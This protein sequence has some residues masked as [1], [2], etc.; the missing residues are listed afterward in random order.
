MIDIIDKKNCC[1]CTACASIC[2]H[3]AISMQPDALGFL[4]P[5]V[6]KD[7][8]VNCGVCDKV[9]A[10]NGEYDKSYNFDYPLAY[11]ARHKDLKQIQKS[12]SGAA[13]AFLSD[14]ILENGGVVYGAGYTDFF[15]VVHQ[16]ATTKEERDKLRRSKYVQSDLTNVFVQVK[17]DLC[18]GLTVLFSGTP[19]QAAGLNSYIGKKFREN[20]ILVDII[21]HGVPG[22]Y[23][24]RDYLT[25]LQKKERKKLI[26]INFRDKELGGWRGSVESFTFEKKDKRTYDFRFYDQITIRQSCNVCPY[27]NFKRP[28]DITIGDFWGVEKTRAAYMGED[29][30]GCS[31][32]LLN[33]NKGVYLFDQVKK[34]IEYESM[35][36][37]ECVQPQLQNPWVAHPQRLQFEKEYPALGFERTMKKYKIMGWRRHLDRQIR[38]WKNMFPQTWKDGI[39]NILHHN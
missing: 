39:K 19:C 8:C 35:L 15:R 25:Y 5:V 18:N 32:L 21:C 3:H 36:I 11:A 23:I 10:F 9:C 6:D 14:Y 16:R 31:L 33:T 13:F 4:Y 38:R 1:G 7:K 28:S 30:K 37:N 22:P 26:E 24:L 12:Q 2:A 20:L 29:N 34:N 17:R 27:T